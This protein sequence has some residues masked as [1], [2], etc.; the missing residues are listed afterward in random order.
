MKKGIA[1]K[2]SSTLEAAIII[3]IIM[4][5]ML[6]SV[7]VSAKLYSSCRELALEHVEETETKLDES[8]EKINEMYL[9]RVIGD[10]IE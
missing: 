7:S 5:I 10:L 3:P 8:G 2:G 1:L 6:M 4:L 9:Y